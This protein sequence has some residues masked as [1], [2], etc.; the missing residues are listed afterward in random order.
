MRAPCALAFL[1]V[2]TPFLKTAS[3]Q[4]QVKPLLELDGETSEPNLSP[5][6]KTLIFEW[7]KPDYSCA[8]C[9]RSIAGGPVVLFAG[10]DS[11]HSSPYSPRWSPAGNLVAFARFYSHFDVHLVTRSASGGTERDLGNVCWGQAS[12]SPDSRFLVAS[13]QTESEDCRPT[14]YSPATGR[15][16][17]LSQKGNFP[18]FSPSGRILAFADGKALKLLRVDAGYRPAGP[19]TTLVRELFE[20]SAVNWTPDGKQIVYQFQ[21]DVPHI[22]RIA[23]VPGARPQAMPDLTS[24]LSIT[25]LL[26][27]GSALA[28]E[29][30]QVEALWR[31]DLCST[32]PKVERVPDL[33]CSPGIPGCSPN[34]RFR[35]FVT[36]RTGVFQVWL[37]N[38]DGTNEHPL[39]KSVP[40][41][42]DGVTNLVGWSPDGKWI[43]FVVFPAQGNADLRSW[44]YI[45]PSSGGVARRLGKEAFAFDNPSWSRDSKSLYGAQG[46]PADDQGHDLKHPLVRVDIADGK[47]SPLGADGMWP[48]VSPDGRF[49]YF[50]TSPYPKLLRIPIEGGNKERLSDQGDFLWF[51][52]AVGA[53]YLYLFQKP[54]RNS[55]GRIHKL[56]RFDPESRQA[57]EL[58]DIPFQPRFAHLSPDEHSLYFGQLDDPKRRVVLVRGLL[59]PQ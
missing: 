58:A 16:T 23:P 18:V 27:D 19:A 45:V 26:A 57:T 28:T 11:R 53:R 40:F 42:D 30:T 59:R 7:C 15:E 34:G 25:Q 37:S 35:A 44:L 1:C 41:P 14:L 52:A 32:P 56:I 33:E 17:R 43:A 48:Q 46:W 20:I 38:A 31:A 54:P 21:G 36:K 5:D 8:I 2:C 22:R 39:V 4:I 55:V 3:A 24:D 50:F 6:G 12:W 29:T 47:L 9:T 10:R 13:K 49:L 51:C